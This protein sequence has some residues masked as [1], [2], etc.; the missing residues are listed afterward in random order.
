[1]GKRYG[2]KLKLTED[3]KNISGATLSCLH[4]TAGVKRLLA[5]HA[6]VLPPAG[7]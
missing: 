2:A 6:L 4:V 3:I 1:M 7:G 5:T